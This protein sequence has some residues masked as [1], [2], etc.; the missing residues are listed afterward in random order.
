MVM[1]AAE[2]QPDEHAGPAGEQERKEQV[3]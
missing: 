1:A 3:H 2:Q